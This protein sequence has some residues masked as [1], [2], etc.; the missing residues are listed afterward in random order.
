MKLRKDDQLHTH[1]TIYKPSQTK[2]ANQFQLLIQMKYMKAS[3]SPKIHLTKLI[4][5]LINSSPKTK[6]WIEI[7][8]FLKIEQLKAILTEKWLH[9]SWAYDVKETQKTITRIKSALITEE[10]TISKL[11]HK[12]Y[13]GSSSDKCHLDI[14]LQLF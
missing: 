9:M 10:M 3:R 8:E 12:D 11:N 7:L 2:K 13:T 1:K 14:L 5:H 6:N 4:A